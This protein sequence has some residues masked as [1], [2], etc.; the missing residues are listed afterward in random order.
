VDHLLPEQDAVGP[1]RTAAIVVSVVAALELAVI[2]GA[3][4]VVIGRSVARHAV[5]A[6]A[7][8]VD[9]PVKPRTAATPIDAPAGKASRPRSRTV[10]TVLNGGQISGAAAGQAQV[11]RGLGY[12][13]GTVGNAPHPVA[14]TVIEYRSGF[15]AEAARLASD[16]HVR[17]ISPL[18]GLRA[19]DL[20]GAQLALVIST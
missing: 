14:R 1:W 9:A 18:D 17:T 20:S 16:L 10:V 13:L 12:A 7:R 15:R 5:R 2:A 6:A 4:V 11:L 3:G 8:H 19:H